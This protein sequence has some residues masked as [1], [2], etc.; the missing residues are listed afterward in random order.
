MR[1]R[2]SLLSVLAAAVAVPAA[3]LAGP[4]SPP[5]PLGWEPQIVAAAATA[6]AVSEPVTAHYVSSVRRGLAPGVGS[7]RGLQIQT[8]RLKRAISARFPEIVE[9][10]GVRPDS[11]RWHPNG[12][13]IDVII[14]DWDTAAGRALGDRIAKFALANAKRFKLEHVIWKRTYHPTGGK[15]RLM[16]DLGNP[17]ANHYTHVHIATYGGGYPKGGEVYYD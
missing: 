15:S 6:G 13:A 4:V 2:R 17:D 10:G 14:P 1:F 8:I 3:V 5:Q 9:I 12:L 16:D 11:M 7:E